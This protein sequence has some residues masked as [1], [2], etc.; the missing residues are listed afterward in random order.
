MRV[1]IETSSPENT[2]MQQV[3][4]VTDGLATSL[5]GLPSDEHAENGAGEQRLRKILAAIMAFR[6]GN[7]SARLPTEWAGT[8]G[9][10]AEAFNQAIGQEDRIAREVARLSVTVG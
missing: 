5:N 4:R 2:I 1:I 6:D 8:E 3:D 7:F 9:R 10:I